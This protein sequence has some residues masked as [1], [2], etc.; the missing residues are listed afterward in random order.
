MGE[1]DSNEK[2]IKPSAKGQITSGR[3]GVFK[4]I[5]DEV[6]LKNLQEIKNNF[7]EEI[8]IPSTIDWLYEVCSGFVNDMFKTPGVGRGSTPLRG[9]GSGAKY[10]SYSKSY[11]G[12]RE[13]TS[14]SSPSGVRS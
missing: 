14:D 10:Q 7:V 5:L 3:R 6:I 9:Y 11:R 1:V 4:V 2:D 12:T 8:I 13:R